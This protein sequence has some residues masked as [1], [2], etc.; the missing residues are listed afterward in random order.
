MSKRF[1]AEL[2]D[3]IQNIMPAYSKKAKTSSRS[4]KRS[5]SAKR[6]V[7]KGNVAYVN[8]RVTT[9]P[10]GPEAK[11][12]DTK[13]LGSFTVYNTLPALTSLTA[14]MPQGAGSAM[15]IGNRIKFR[16]FGMKMNF[17]LNTASTVNAS[18]HWAL[19][20]DKQPDGVTPSVGTIWTDTTSN[21]NQID[22]D[23]LQRFQILATGN[24]ALS[25][26]GP[27]NIYRERFVKADIGTR[28]PDSTSEA[29]TNGLYLVFTSNALTGN[30][31]LVDFSVR[32]KYT[33]E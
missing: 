2:E 3:T 5:Y 11:Q 7:S 32:S 13:N 27:A 28:Y 33:D 24:E 31:I 26:T 17:R 14:G 21:L 30:P 8:G 15:R 6:T 16:S 10:Q 25:G 23:N 19:V 1:F 22:D 20:L 4:S 18:I 29:T 12:F 9:G